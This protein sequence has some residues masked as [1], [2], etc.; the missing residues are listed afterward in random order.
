[1]VFKSMRRTAPVRSMQ[2]HNVCV[3]VRGDGSGPPKTLLK[4]IC[5]AALPGDMVALMGPSGEPAL[6]VSCHAA[7]GAPAR[8][9]SVKAPCGQHAASRLPCSSGNRMS[10]CS[11]RA[12]MAALVQYT[13]CV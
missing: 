8:W 13:H 12:S 9:M 7:A 3:R 1:M 6:S 5:G 10:G 2:W 11:Q 4:N